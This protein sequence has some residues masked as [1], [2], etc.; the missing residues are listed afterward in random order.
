MARLRP[1]DALRSRLLDLLI[2]ILSRWLRPTVLDAA[3]VSSCDRVPCY[4]LAQRSP[5]DLVATELACR[6]EG[7]PSPRRPL[8]SD[9]LDSPRACFSLSRPEGVLFRRRS[10]RRRSELIG[11]L[12]GAARNGEHL[13]VVPV[14]IFWGRAPAREHSMFRVL[15]SERWT[16][17]S[18]LRRW[19]GILFNRTHLFVRFGTPIPVEDMLDDARREE[20]EERRLA[21][22]LRTHFRRAREALIGPDLS[23]RRTLLN[24]VLTTRSVTEAIQAHSA[25]HRIKVTKAARIAR[26]HA[27]EIAADLSFP[28]IRFFDVLL[29]WLWNRLYDGIEL[30]GLEP[31][32]EIADT[33]TVIYVPSHRSHVDYLLMSY[34][35]FYNGLM[36]PHVAAG[37]N[38]NIPVVGSLLRR[39]GAF[40]MRRS[41]RDDPLYAAVFEAYLDRMYAAGFAVEYFIEGGRSRTGRLL[42]ARGGM[43][44]MTLRSFLR[45]PDRPLAFVP[46]YF[47]YE[48]VI[49]A[50]SYMGELRGQAKR[51]ESLGGV[52]RSVRFL[53]QSFGKVHVN[54][55]MPLKLE[56][57]LDVEAPQWSE[58]R[59]TALA[60]DSSWLAPAVRQLGEVLQRRTNAAAAVNPVALM[61][62]VLLATP[63]QAL[64]ERDLAAQLDCL[65]RLVRAAP[66]SDRVTITALDG[67]GVARYCEKIGVLER[68]AHPLGDILWLDNVQR[69]QLTWYRNN[70]VHLFALP[71]L[72]AVL[73]A[74]G[75][76]WTPSALF[77]YCRRVHPYLRSELFLPVDAEHLEGDIRAQTG[78]LE[79]S[80]LLV[81]DGDA[82]CAP[83]PE[84][85]AHAQLLRLAA[86]LIPTLERYYIAIALLEAQ[87]P[88]TLTVDEL[89]A[90]CVLTAQRTA[91]LFGVDAPEFFDATLFRRF[92]DQLRAEGAAELDAN[93]RLV[94]REDLHRILV[95]ATRVLDPAFCQGVTMARQLPAL[96]PVTQTPAATDAPPPETAPGARAG[97]G[98]GQPGL[99]RKDAAAGTGER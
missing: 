11:A 66:P 61:A 67:T 82:L 92:V 81:R 32:K 49:E 12:L 15:L 52:L 89:V 3:G 42:P 13:S 75:R 65:L 26:G 8:V 95:A 16:A 14:S 24:H 20:I 77:D 30:A 40:F 9:S 69:V 44:S 84:Q 19:L 50:R 47:G 35:L 86:I 37:R 18:S 97:P 31:V 72:I 70:I 87:P 21:R 38:L 36:L 90:A 10:P 58:Q 39:A 46:V 54:F 59:D 2:R 64:D 98:A 34:V 99:L 5:L 96:L 60:G 88:G 25:E 7:L 43:L 56:E 28:V 51:S 41:F 29:S 4:A 45:H 22:L 57:F 76:S 55:G 68:E 1:I 48:R 93:D 83:Q 79:E 53:R 23:H 6:S 17:A 62:T 94:Y 63:R 71:S 27:E 80:G 33:H 85:P 74:S 78:L 91:R 73:A